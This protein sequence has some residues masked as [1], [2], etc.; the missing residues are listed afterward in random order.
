LSRI[1]AP[2]SPTR[3][4]LLL[5]A[6]EHRGPVR[7]RTT[8]HALRK[9]ELITLITYKNKHCRR[10]DKR[11]VTASGLFSVYVDRIAVGMRIAAHPRTDPGGRDSRTGLPPRVLDGE[12]NAGP[13]MKDTGWR[14]ELCRE[15]GHPVPCGAIPL[16]SLYNRTSPDIGHIV[17]EG[18]KASAVCG[19]RVIRKVSADDLSEARLGWR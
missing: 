15:F 16:A 1:V 14:Q 10:H 19:Y 18:S 4:V 6:V 13:R 11:S 12:A 3:R 5:L 9:S 17:P 7:I 2:V 8:E